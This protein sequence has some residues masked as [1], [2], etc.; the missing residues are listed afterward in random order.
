MAQ[1]FGMQRLLCTLLYSYTYPE[2]GT[3]IYSY[4][5]NVR[6]WVLKTPLGNFTISV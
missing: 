3:H 5:G 2:W 6:N 4:T 1:L